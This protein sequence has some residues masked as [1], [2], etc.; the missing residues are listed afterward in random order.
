VDALRGDGARYVGIAVL[1]A[2]IFG[3]GLYS[4]G[5]ASEGVPP[6]WV[7]AA[8]RVAG[9]ILLTLP[10]AL[11][12]RLRA[13][14]R[15]LPLLVFAGLAEV[16]GVYVFAWGARESIAVTAMLSSQFAVV[17]ALVAHLLG[18]RIS[19]RQWAGVAAVTSGVVVIT[20]ARL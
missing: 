18:E 11:T 9:V 13:P 16:A 15:L 12:S 6:S 2:L 10:L 4:S 3:L 14:G 5:R 8:G 1:A 17:A 20:L 19:L 7:V